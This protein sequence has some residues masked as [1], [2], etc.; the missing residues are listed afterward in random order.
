MSGKKRADFSKPYI[1][2]F[3]ILADFKMSEK[4]QPIFPNTGKTGR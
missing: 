3:T 2:A 1:S 4:I